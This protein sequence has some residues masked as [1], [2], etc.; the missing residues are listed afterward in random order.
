MLNDDELGYWV[1]T[2]LISN[3]KDLAPTPP[4]DS[5]MITNVDVQKRAYFSGSAA[6]QFPAFIS[7]F[8][9]DNTSEGTVDLPLA[10]AFLARY[11]YQSGSRLVC[12][13]SFCSTN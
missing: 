13:C 1:N 6:A 2:L 10:R 8:E 3:L 5:R 4:A 12:N 9:A 7:V 11:D